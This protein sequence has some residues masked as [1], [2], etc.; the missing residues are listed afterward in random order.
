MKKIFVTLISVILLA[1]CSLER[2]DYTEI[3]PDT[4][5]KTE[6]DIKLS[7]NYLY[8]YFNMGDWNGVYRADYSGYQVVSDMTTDVMWS[9][10]GWHSDE[11]YFHQWT[12]NTGNIQSKFWDMYSGYNFLS[13]ARNT[14]RRIEASKVADNVKAVYLG[15]AHAL[16]GWYALFLYDMF[17]TVPVASD[18]ILDDP[19][20]F[21]YL[22]RA[23]RDEWDEMMET[24]LRTAIDLLPDAPE[25]RGRM[26]KGSARM[27]LLKYY[28]IRG[29]YDK[30]ETLCRELYAMEG[31][32]G[33][34]N[35]YSSVFAID[36]V[37]NNEVILQIAGN[38]NAT[39]TVNYMTAECL[40]GDM[41]WTEKSQGWGGY[42]MPWDFY[43]TFEAGD[44]RKACLYDHYTN[45]SGETITRE[46]FESAAGYLGAIVLKYG[47]DENMLGS[48]AGNDLV[49]YRWSDVLLTLAELINRNGGA[50]TAEAYE[51]VNRVRSRAGLANLTPGLT[52]DAFNEA[53]LL[54]RGHEFYFE[55]LRR[56]DLIRFGK[57]IEYAN[58]RIAKANAAGSNYYGVDES[59]NLFPIHQSF[60]D[61]SRGMVKQNPNY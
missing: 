23:T 36:N 32:Y 58:A 18:D 37:D 5:F 40:P 15:E 9:N 25:A 20:T 51:L 49:I 41:V 42:V 31:I 34:Q 52:Y 45:T 48:N 21:V 19:E 28:M 35:D 57:Y 1:S 38:I 43:D 27:L 3:Y 24:D 10:W 8:Y 54:E 30:A 13:M 22:P 17:G 55:G 60:I 16:R 11:Y 33:L 61:E 2:E 56:Q 29:L 7:V 50:P 59:H 53:L 14:I 6:T 26:G 4:I 46:N 47:K 12:V 44:K 39:S